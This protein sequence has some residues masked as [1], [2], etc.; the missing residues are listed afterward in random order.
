MVE[1]SGG[2]MSVDY[3]ILLTLLSEIF[4]NVMRKMKYDGK[5]HV[6]LR[7]KNRFIS[8]FQIREHLSL[9]LAQSFTRDYMKD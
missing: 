8:I 5:P 2:K 1:Y 9:S 3:K 7:L 4:H 6:Y